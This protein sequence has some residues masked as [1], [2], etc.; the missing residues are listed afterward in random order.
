MNR[1]KV[2]ELFCARHLI[3]FGLLAVLA[4]NVAVRWRLLDMPLERDEGEYAYSGQLILQ[5]IPPYQLAYNMK[6]PGTYFAYAALMKIFGETPQGVHLGIILVTSASTVFVFLIGRKLLSA[7]GGVMAAAAFA[8][9]SALPATY[10][11]AGHAT[12]FVTLF[13]CAGFFALL[14]VEEKNPLRWSALSGAAFGVAI[15]MKQPAVLFVPFSLAWILARAIRQTGSW[16]SALRPLL[17]HGAG[18]ALP[19]APMA[20]GL[21]CAGVWGRFD[22]WTLQYAR[23]YVSFFP[24]PVAIRQFVSG[25]WPI[26]APAVGLWLLGGIGLV[27]ILGKK[28]R[29]RPVVLCG[30]MFLAGMAATC[31]GFYFRGHYFLPAMPGVSL[32]A[33]AAVVI[34]AE[35]LKDFRWFKLLPV[36]FFCFALAALAARNAQIWF[37]QTPLEVTQTFYPLSP[38]P[39]SPVIARYIETNTTPADTVAVLGSE[40][41]IYFLAHRHSASGYIYMYPFTEPQ[42]LAAQM[43]NECISQ[44]EAAKPKY[45]VLMAID[46]SWIQI[47]YPGVTADH[48]LPD[49]WN[50]YSQNYELVGAVDMAEGKPSEFFW[51][52]QAAIHAGSPDH[53]ISIFRRK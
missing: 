24:A 19:L 4:F 48:S 8:G 21:A 41:Q 52:E 33:A 35:R 1:R 16:R 51:D 47:I 42:S 2:V 13:I 38:F 53:R 15:L 34:L 7:A 32:L 5:G 31:P 3:W 27:L 10:G 39:E 11:L 17:A 18:C 36:V 37:V 29:Q 49:W 9:L 23:Q 6:F 26:F 30:V 20:I 12:H 28:Q 43:R 45:V 25:F 44:I 46:G 14:K 22:F 50:S 40:P